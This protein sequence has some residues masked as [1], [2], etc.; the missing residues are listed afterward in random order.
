MLVF[1]D[2]V[3]IPHHVGRTCRE[4]KSGLASIMMIALFSP[5]DRE[6]NTVQVVELVLEIQQ[7]TIRD[8]S[9]AVERF[10]KTVHN[11]VHVTMEYSRMG[12][13]WVPRCMMEVH[14]N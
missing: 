7:D 6:H 11:I 3:L 9:I 12:A 8:S 4:F 5:A 2:G 1:G 13:W 14:R 10:V